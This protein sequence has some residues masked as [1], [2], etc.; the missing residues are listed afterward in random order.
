MTPAAVAAYAALFFAV[1]EADPLSRELRVEARACDDR[2]V[3]A[4]RQGG[5]KLVAARVQ[6]EASDPSL[7]V[8]LAE[9][10]ERDDLRDELLD[11]DPTAYVWA[12]DRLRRLHGRS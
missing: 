10:F 1:R 11:R 2:L 7:G 4:A 9:R 12:V 8:P 3:K 5:A 6:Y